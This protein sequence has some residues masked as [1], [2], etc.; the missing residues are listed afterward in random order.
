MNSSCGPES[1]LSDDCA[2][3]SMVGQER[4]PILAVIKFRVAG[5][6]AIYELGRRPAEETALAVEYRAIKLPKIITAQ[7]NL[8]PLI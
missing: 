8:N 1:Q 3:L 7:P 2:P 4:E 6:A 5:T